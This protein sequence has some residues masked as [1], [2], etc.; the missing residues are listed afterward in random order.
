MQNGAGRELNPWLS[1]WLHPRKTMR[2]IRQHDPDDQVILLTSLAGFSEILVSASRF[3]LG[4]HLDIPVIFAMAVFLGPVS[5]ITGLIAGS[6]L[7]WWTGTWLGGKAQPNLIRAAIAW[8]FVP[9]ICYSI[10]WIPQYIFLQDVLFK[11]KVVVY[12]SSI[13][14]LSAG[15]NSLRLIIG[16]WSLAIF[17]NGLS[18]A[19]GYST[20]RA[21]I[22]TGMSFIIVLTVVWFIASVIGV[23]MD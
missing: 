4:D 6:L 15:F 10:L 2:W 19:Q 13:H 16:L 20:G 8:S 12:G 5:G 17:I 7:L 18:E 22:N 14:L 1:I 11:S 3:S 9:V 21:V 23:T